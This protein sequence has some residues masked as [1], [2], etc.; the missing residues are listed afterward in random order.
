MVLLKGCRAIGTNLIWAFRG[1]L[2]LDFGRIVIPYV[3]ALRAID[4]ED[5]RYGRRRPG[6]WEP[7][8]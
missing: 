6:L 7:K 1:G 2:E 8:G 3:V 5:A 4:H